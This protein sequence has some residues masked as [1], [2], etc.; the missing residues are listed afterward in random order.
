LLPSSH[1]LSK[2]GFWKRR[3][4]RKRFRSK[5]E[6]PRLAQSNQGYS[7]FSWLNIFVSQFEVAALNLSIE[8]GGHFNLLSQNEVAKKSMVGTFFARGFIYYRQK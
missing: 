2:A 3:T 7:E 5:I 1:F 8:Q 6:S 4:C